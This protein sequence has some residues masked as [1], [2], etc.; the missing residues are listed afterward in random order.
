MIAERLDPEKI[1]FGLEGELAK[2]L[3]QLCARSSIPDLAAHFRSQKPNQ[4]NQRY[5][6][7]GSG[8]S[9]PHVRIDDLAAPELILGLSAG[10]LSFNNEKIHIVLLL[11]TPAEQPPQ[12]L[13]LLQRVCSLLPAIRG[14]LL[15]QRDARGVLQ[16]IA[17][18]EQQ[19]AV[20]R[21]LEEKVLR[22]VGEQ[23]IDVI[24]ADPREHLA[25][26]S[27]GQRQVTHRLKTL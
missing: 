19:S 26:V 4:N 20:D 2:A 23:F 22:H 13:Q 9:L 7:I 1:V 16:L 24:D 25:A 5:T 14:Q 10:G 11:A 27:V 12:H 21:L 17:R 8:I 15:A 6:S 18:A 3:D